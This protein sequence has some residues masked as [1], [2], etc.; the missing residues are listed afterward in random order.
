MNTL[1]EIRATGISVAVKNQILGVP[2]IEEISFSNEVVEDFIDRVVND[3]F[4]FQ[5]IEQ[6]SETSNLFNRAFMY[7]FGKGAELAFFARIGTTIDR[8]SYSFDKAMLAKCGEQIP[9]YIR[10]FKIYKKSNAM[11]EMYQEMYKHTKGSQERIISEGLSFPDCMKT[12]LLGGF[13]YGTHI[14]LTIELSEKDRLVHYID[15]EDIPYDPDN[16]HGN[17]R[18]EDYKV[19]NYTIG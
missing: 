17:Y 14:C 3:L 11:I 2:K 10:A 7:V 12:I 15:E 1:D 13:F 18:P 19:V 5:T 8:I 16:Y 6:F 9:E 4:E